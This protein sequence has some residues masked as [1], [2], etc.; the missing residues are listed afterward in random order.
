MKE[1]IGLSK[2]KASFCFSDVSSW[3]VVVVK[4]LSTEGVE[5]VWV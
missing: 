4:A 3:V 2:G 1:R 5:F